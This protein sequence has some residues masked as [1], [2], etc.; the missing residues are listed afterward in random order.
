MTSALLDSNV[1]IGLASKHDQH[2]EAAR[3]LIRGFDTG[4]L[5]RAVVTNY[6]LAEALGFIHA[7]IGQEV[8][9]DLY[10]RLKT[11]SGFE[12]VV[13]PKADFGTAE[14]IFLGIEPLS[15]VDATLV[16]FARRTGTEVLYSLDDDFDTV[17]DVTRFETAANPFR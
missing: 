12:V 13:V 6:V 5:P 10:D 16:A 14:S 1:L 17:P 4:E 11:G 3:N 9:V 7:K 15:F 2:H 8:V